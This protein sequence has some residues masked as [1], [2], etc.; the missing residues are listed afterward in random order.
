MIDVTGRRAFKA[1]YP[2][3][4]ISCGVAI[5]PGDQIF[6]APGNEAPSGLGCCG[7]RPDDEL[8]VVQRRDETESSEN[9]ADTI[10]R[11]MPRGRTAR[12]MCSRCFQIPASN[13]TCGCD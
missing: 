5:L 10:A 6:Y 9:P 3:N 2:G 1:Q 4:C 8:T 13:G 7:D 11:V 12:D